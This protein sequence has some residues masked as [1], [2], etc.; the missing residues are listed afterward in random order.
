[1]HLAPLG[2]LNAR[3]ELGRSIIVPDPARYELVQEAKRLHEQGMS[4]RKICKVMEQE[5]L[6]SKRGKIVSPMAMWS[7]LEGR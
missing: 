2:W 6:R 7:A 4:I 3:D 1:M 5:G